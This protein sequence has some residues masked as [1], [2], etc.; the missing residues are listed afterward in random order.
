MDCLCVVVVVVAATTTATTTGATATATAAAASSIV[1]VG[2]G[3]MDIILCFGVLTECFQQLQ[4]QTNNF[5][6]SR[7][8]TLIIFLFVIHDRCS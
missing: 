6:I 4:R 7:S 3:I 1:T 2:G 5:F 8:R